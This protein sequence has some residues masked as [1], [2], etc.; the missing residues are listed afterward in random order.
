MEPGD[1]VVEVGAGLGSLTVALASTGARVLA[2]ELDRAL[3]PA[4]EEVLAAFPN[5][6]LRVADA[7]QVDWPSV[8]R[9]G[10]WKMVSNLPYN[11]ATPLLLEMLER[12][13]GVERYLVMVQREVAERLAA[14]AGDDAYGAPSVKV[15]YRAEARVVRR[16]PASVFWP[17]PKV[18]SALVEL[19]PRPAPVTVPAGEVFRVVDEGFAERRKTMANALRR[20]GLGAEEAAQVLARCGLEALVR[21]ER[22]SLED[23]ARIA[24]EVR[25]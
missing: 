9:P 3:A 6:R 20:L 4:L 2:V 1:R 8:V 11:V 21:A 24:M 17:A 7:L 18:E 12:A 5:A 15:A 22:L 19:V 14:R 13:P 25:R 10:K 16:V 23:F